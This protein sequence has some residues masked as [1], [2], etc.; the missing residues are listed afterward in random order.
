MARIHKSATL[1]YRLER[2]PRILEQRSGKLEPQ[3]LLILQRGKAGSGFK[4]A[5][6]ITRAHA[7][8]FSQPGQAN[9]L[10]KMC[11]QPILHSMDTRMQVVAERKINAGLGV[12]TLS[13]DKDHEVARYLGRQTRAMVLLDEGKRH[14]YT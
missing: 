8:Q 2:K 6:Q 5:Y 10:G 9:R 7:G 14:V 13:A 3:P 1:R 11:A 4:G 12:A